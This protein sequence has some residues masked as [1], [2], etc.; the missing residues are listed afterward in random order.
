[1]DIDQLAGLIERMGVPI[2]GF[3]ATSFALYKIVMYI[4]K[5]WTRTNNEAHERMRGE[6]AN[7]IEKINDVEIQVAELS[8]KVDM[9][10]DLSQGVSRRK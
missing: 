3:L 10:I 5:E 9:V 8:T 1:M 6:V 2:V 7:V 4:L